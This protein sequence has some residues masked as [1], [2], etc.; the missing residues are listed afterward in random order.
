M[1]IDKQIFPFVMTWD[2]VETNYRRKYIQEL[3][4]AYLQSIYLVGRS[5]EN[6][7]EYFLGSKAWTRPGRNW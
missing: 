3:M 1:Q 5:E 2:G 7:E 6:F 4:S